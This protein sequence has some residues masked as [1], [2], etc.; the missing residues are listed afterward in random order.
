VEKSLR[1][2]LW[3][4]PLKTAKRKLRNR[5]PSQQ[6]TDEHLTGNPS[7]E[8]ETGHTWNR[9][10]KK[11]PLRITFI[12]PIKRQILRKRKKENENPEISSKTFF[13]RWSLPLPPNRE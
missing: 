2:F 13:S 5:D 11:D 1:D 4:L 8:N 3:L 7:T 10:N 6:L 12:Y 9:N